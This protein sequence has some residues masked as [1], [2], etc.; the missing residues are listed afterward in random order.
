VESLG[1][2]SNT[3]L[4][5]VSSMQSLV[6]TSL[7]TYSAEITRQ[8]HLLNS[9]SADGRRYLRLSTSTLTTRQHL[10]VMDAQ[11]GPGSMSPMASTQTLKLSHSISNVPSLPCQ[12]LWRQ[13]HRKWPQRFALYRNLSL[14][15]L[16]YVHLRLRKLPD[17]PKYIINP[18]LNTWLRCARRPN[19]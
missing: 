3:T 10:N 7:S 5:G 14:Y 13:M 15:A 18:R 8:I 17:L 11:S 6:S 9:T 1:S 16:K 4:E 2:V 12:S 19:R